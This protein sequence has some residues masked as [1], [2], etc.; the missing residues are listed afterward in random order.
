MICFE[1]FAGW[2]LLESNKPVSNQFF[3]ERD[4]ITLKVFTEKNVKTP[5]QMWKFYQSETSVALAKF[6][7][8]LLTIEKFQQISNTKSLTYFS[9]L[10]IMSKYPLHLRSFS[11]C[12]TH[13]R[14]L[15]KCP[16]YSHFKKMLIWGKIFIT[17]VHFKHSLISFAEIKQVSITFMYYILKQPFPRGFIS[18]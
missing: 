15:R 14:N 5:K 1:N 16:W 4:T 9:H 18:Y 12:P 11:K 10:R 6:E 2:F 8:M 7:E 3:I 17:F 13:L